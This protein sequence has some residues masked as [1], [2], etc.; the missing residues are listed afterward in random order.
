VDVGAIPNSRG[1][2]PRG[3]GGQVGYGQVHANLRARLGPPD[4]HQCVGCGGQAHEWAYDGM[5]PEE[6]VGPNGKR[7][8]RY[9]VKSEHYEPRCR[10]CHRSLDARRVTIC[11]KCGSTNRQRRPNGKSYCRDC[12]NKSRR[13]RHAA[14]NL[15]RR[16]SSQ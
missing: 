14:D 12:A 1:R 5:D 10:S 7:M 13:E 2:K 9:S 11:P 15:S 4:A 16:N 8:C 6:L 3:P